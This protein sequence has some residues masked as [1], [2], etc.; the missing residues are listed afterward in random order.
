MFHF[1]LRLTHIDEFIISRTFSH[2]A[3][4]AH[5]HEELP[6]PLDLFKDIIGGKRKPVAWTSAPLSQPW[7]NAHPVFE[8]FSTLYLLSL[9][10]PSFSAKMRECISIHIGQAGIQVG[11]AFWELCCL[12]HSIQP[13]GQMLGD[14][15]VGRGD[16]AF[17]TSFSETGAGKHVPRAIFVDLEP[18]VIDEVRNGRC[19]QQ[20]LCLRGEGGGSGGGRRRECSW[21][22]RIG[23]SGESR[24]N[25]GN[26]RPR[27]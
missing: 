8:L 24:G 12:G 16:D 6:Q 15:T 21:W 14:K 7:P 19:C 10:F 25:P 5:L 20:L 9:S 4:I 1:A 11:N 27:V 2:E 23:K 13:N 3:S 18:T 17:N 26:L 22:Q